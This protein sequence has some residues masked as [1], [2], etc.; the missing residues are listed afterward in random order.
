MSQGQNSERVKY[1]V[2]E[3]E[4]TGLRK[5]A[6]GGWNKLSKDNV[7]GAEVTE[8]VGASSVGLL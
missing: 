8:V 4:C 5:E 6:L 2:P 1:L 3:Q 7:I